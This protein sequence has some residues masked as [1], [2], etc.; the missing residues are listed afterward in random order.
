MHDTNPQQKNPLEQLKRYVE[1]LDKETVTTVTVVVVILALVTGYSFAVSDRFSES[2]EV[3]SETAVTEEIEEEVEDA[4]PATA[5][6][7]V[8]GSSS[9]QTR[10]TIDA[11]AV[12]VLFPTLHEKAT[13]NP[14]FLCQDIIDKKETQNNVYYYVQAEYNK[15]N[16][17]YGGYNNAYI[18]DDLAEIKT[19]LEFVK[20]ECAHRGY[21]ID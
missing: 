18:R 14:Q 17:Q 20:T 2:E 15:L 3:A 5:P 1:G 7:G 10:Y 6:S 19:E 8:R 11:D 16:D 21:R 9:V 4:A 12:N 13:I